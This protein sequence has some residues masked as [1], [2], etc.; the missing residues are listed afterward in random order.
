MVIVL[1]PP[2][3]II[4]FLL[5]VGHDPKNIVLGL[6][7]HELSNESLSDFCKTVPTNECFP[8][9][10]SCHFLNNFPNDIFQWVGK[11]VEGE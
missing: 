5:I 6:V 9:G 7:N 4:T 10:V 11:K 8:S 2:I 3:Q 1:L